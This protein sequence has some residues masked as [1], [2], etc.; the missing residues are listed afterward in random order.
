M[1]KIIQDHV[2]ETLFQNEVAEIPILMLSLT[3]IFGQGMSL[4]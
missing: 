1:L 2:K 4:H 3:V